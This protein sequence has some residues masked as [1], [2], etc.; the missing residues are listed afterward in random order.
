MEGRSTKHLT[1]LSARLEA[2]ETHLEQQASE[3]R[4]GQSE[5]KHKTRLAA[6]EKSLRKELDLIKTEYRSGQL[7]HNPP[8]FTFTSQTS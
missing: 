6:L 2:V 5:T 4:V 8:P 3:D 7:I 1:L